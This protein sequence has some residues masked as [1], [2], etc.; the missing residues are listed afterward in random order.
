MS[1]ML[2]G[3]LSVSGQSGLFKM[4]SQAKNSIIVESLVDGKRMP[5]Y[6][7]SRISALEDIS[8][9][10]EQG[11]EKLAE[12][13][14][15]IYEK[16]GGKQAIS[17]KSSA[18]ELKSYF[19]QVLPDYDKDR[20]YVSDIKKVIMWYNLLVD[21]NIIKFDEETETSAEEA[22]NEKSTQKEEE[23]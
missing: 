17:H 19:N 5:A 9:F 10:T 13:F 18:N 21:K 11:D 8:I 14:K 4:I 6:A 16:E 7:T 12:V 15:N 2:K 1:E 22:P 20:V 23:A 3:I